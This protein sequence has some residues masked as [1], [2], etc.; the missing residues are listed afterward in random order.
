[1]I[2]SRK[3]NR[4]VGI[5]SQ[6]RSEERETRA[7]ARAYTCM[8]SHPRVHLFL[9][10]GMRGTQRIAGI[11]LRIPLTS[12]RVSALKKG[13]STQNTACLAA[14]LAQAAGTDYVCGL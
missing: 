10:S 8:R 7:S 11:F 14:R 9:R 13:V 3:I 2:P 1:M 12:L 4:T 6:A 5:G